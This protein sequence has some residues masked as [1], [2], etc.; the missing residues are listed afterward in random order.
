MCL[1]RVFFSINGQA[2]N[3]FDVSGDGTVALEEFVDTWKSFGFQAPKEDVVTALMAADEDGDEELDFH[4]FVHMISSG[5]TAMSGEI[6]GQLSEMREIFSIF[7]PNGDGAISADEI[8]PVLKHFCGLDE[9]SFKLELSDIERLLLEVD[10]DGNGELDFFEFA[11]MMAISALPHQPKVRDKTPQALVTLGTALKKLP[12]ERSRQ[13]QGEIGG[14]ILDLGFD[15]QGK[16]QLTQDIHNELCRHLQINHHR[17][18]SSI[19]KH[20]LSGASAA[21]QKFVM[22]LKG[23]V[24]GWRRHTVKDEKGEMPKVI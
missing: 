10:D 8:Y 13:M 20:T 23:S 14:A 7:D 9:S 1:R 12:M 3:L 2:F 4:E 18:H 6:Q 17:P 5:R 16:Y 24:T 21:D 11:S 15:L 19:L 22:I